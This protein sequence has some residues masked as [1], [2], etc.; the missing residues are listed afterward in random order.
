MILT[1][2]LKK[3]IRSLHQ[4]KH[5]QN[6][7]KFIAE[8]PKVCKEFLMCKTYDIQ[9]ILATKTWID[10]QGAELTAI[11]QSKLCKVSEKELSQISLLRTP[12][13]LLM[14][15]DKQQK[16][17]T[18]AQESWTIYTDRIQ[19][20]GNMGTIIRIADWYGVGAVLTSPESVDYYNPKVV[21]ASA[22]AHNRIRLD[23]LKG[24][25]LK[26][27]L[28]GPIYGLVLGGADIN[29]YT[30]AEPGVLVVGN[31]SKGIHPGLIERLDYRLMI[32][33]KGGA[34]SLNAAVACGIAC[35]LLMGG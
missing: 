26:A 2:Q 20:P 31:E 8:G 28:L 19:D 21:Q 10:E 3:Y 29:E 11:Q 23:S 17:L 33:R 5:R 12:N 6:Y 32:P 27:A 22:G 25:D 34:E 15:L 4:S 9:H 35:H 30:S 24:E 7:N 1:N 16:D 13:Q 14:V 18:T